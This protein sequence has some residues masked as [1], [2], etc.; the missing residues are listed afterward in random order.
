MA[1]TSHLM[2]QQQPCDYESTMKGLV[3]N[4]SQSKY[5]KSEARE[6]LIGNYGIY[7]GT[8]IMY[9]II[10]SFV[11]MFIYWYL[12]RSMSMFSVISGIVIAFL[13]NVLLS[14]LS[15]GIWVSSLSVS[16]HQPISVGNLFYAFTHH[17]DRFLIV[18]TIKGLIRMIFTIVPV[19]IYTSY[20]FEKNE[21]LFTNPELQSVLRFVL[22]YTLGLLL[23]LGIGGLVTFL[24][25]LRYSMSTFLLIDHEELTAMES[26]RNSSRMMKG[27]LKAY[28]YVSFLSFFGFYSLGYI[29]G[30]IPLLWITPYHHVTVANFY[31]Q[32]NHEL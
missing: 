20:I 11:F 4:M 32:L 29:G 1:V 27:N 18:E 5:L 23:I 6:A 13:C 8:Y 17:S 31:R 21:H 26:L 22:T 2:I 15:T 19:I 25:L 3:Q 16:R 24:I 10:S 14:L 9:S 7:I 12:L 28:F 30:S